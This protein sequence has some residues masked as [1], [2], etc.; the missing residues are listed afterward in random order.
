L[1]YEFFSSL[2]IDLARDGLAEN[3][4]VM[5]KM[6]WFRGLGALSVTQPTALKALFQDSNWSFLVAWMVSVFNLL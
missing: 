6:A 3:W 1:G 5:A 2:T 4:V